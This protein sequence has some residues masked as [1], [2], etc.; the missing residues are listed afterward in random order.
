MVSVLPILYAVLKFFSHGSSAQEPLADVVPLG[1]PAA[2]QLS[3]RPLGSGQSTTKPP[4]RV[5]VVN[6]LRA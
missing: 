4:E 6:A 1:I 2:K 3:T 5:L